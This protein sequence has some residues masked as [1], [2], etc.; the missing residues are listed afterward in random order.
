MNPAPSNKIVHFKMLNHLLVGGGQGK[1]KQETDFFSLIDGKL[2]KLT[3]ITNLH[4]RL[5]KQANQLFQSHR[6][7][8]SPLTVKVFNVERC[9][10]DAK[11]VFLSLKIFGKLVRTFCLLKSVVFAFCWLFD[12]TRDLPNFE[13]AWSSLMKFY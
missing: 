13:A 2:K 5:K 8:I 7:R 9:Q 4:N 1:V 3:K 12:L 6:E 11:N 10:N